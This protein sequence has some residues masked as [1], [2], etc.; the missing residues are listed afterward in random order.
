MS[1]KEPE[2]YGVIYIQVKEKDFC[3]IYQMAI[4]ETFEKKVYIQVCPNES[5]MVQASLIDKDTMDAI[6]IWRGKGYDPQLSTGKPGGC[7]PG[8]CQ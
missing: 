3:D 2:E 1:K 6:D 8:G 7:P 4:K 5:L